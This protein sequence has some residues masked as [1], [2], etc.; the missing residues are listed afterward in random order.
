MNE[1]KNLKFPWL[2]N[3]PANF[4]WGTASSAYQVEGAYNEDGKGASI[5]D[6]FSNIPGNINNN[7][8][9]NTACDQYHRYK[10]DIEFM[11][12]LGIDSYRFS[13]SW[14]RLFPDGRPDHINP[15]GVKFYDSIVDDC[16][17]F[18]IEPIITLFHWD[19]PQIL[20]DQGG[21]FNPQ[22]ID[23]F[24]AYAAWVSE[25]FSDRV[26][27]Y[28]TINEPQIISNLGYHIG[29][30]APGKHL[31]KERTVEI[32]HQLAHA[33]SKAVKAMR[34]VAK[35]DIKIGF[36]STGNLCYPSTT[37]SSSNDDMEAARIATFTTTE[38]NWMF[39][40]QIFCDAVVLGKSADLR[41]IGLENWNDCDE[42]CPPIDFIGINAY[43]GHEVRA[44]KIDSSAPFSSNDGSANQMSY[45][46]PEFVERGP[47]FPRTALKWPITPEMMNYGMR[48]IY[49]RYHLPIFICENGLSCNDSLFLDGKVHDPNRIDF[50]T[51]YLSE[52]GKAIE[53]GAVIAGYMHWSFTD[54][55]EWHSGY[56]E[57]FGLVYVDYQSQKRI[58]KDS[59]WWYKDVIEEFGH[60][61]H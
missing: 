57:R 3:F 31:D 5:W 4:K 25:H 37:K 27:Y 17:R 18:D 55:F 26:T 15:H 6:T 12:Q 33:H 49:D 8:T 38:D 47:G 36:A 45:I 46:I 7:E 22:T 48:F 2:K 16:R 24:S 59:F 58:P 54:N 23:Y 43:N 61:R 53:A 28:C 30:H 40:H 34:A 1:H 14:P 29:V 35:K 60:S 11:H 41:S 42:L 51:R 9:G 20:E 32:I 52:L 39:C 13:I 19:L 10:E 21:W 44:R 50:L 56:D